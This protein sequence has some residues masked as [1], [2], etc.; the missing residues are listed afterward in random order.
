MVLVWPEPSA[1][2]H[3]NKEVS[4]LVNLKT[5][6]LHFEFLKYSSSISC[7]SIHLSGELWVQLSCHPW[8]CATFPF[9][10]PT[11]ERKVGEGYSKS[12]SRFQD[13][14]CHTKPKSSKVNRTN[15]V[16]SVFSTIFKYSCLQD[17]KHLPPPLHKRHPYSQKVLSGSWWFCIRFEALY[18]CAWKYFL[19]STIT[20]FC[21]GSKN[22][23]ECYFAIIHPFRNRIYWIIVQH[24][25][26]V[27]D[28]PASE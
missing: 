7:G 11:G 28:A 21:A 16:R 4:D 19:F 20:G 12:L 18:F 15:H 14:P 3:F 13:L 6:I 9:I 2:K 17:F 27:E 8:Q 25:V 1:L 26:P 23:L 10:D 5:E 22:V 24:Y